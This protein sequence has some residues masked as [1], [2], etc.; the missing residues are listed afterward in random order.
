MFAKRKRHTQMQRRPSMS[1]NNLLMALEF[2]VNC[3]D[4]RNTFEQWKRDPNFIDWLA[5]SY[6]G[7][8][9]NV[10]INIIS[11]F[12]H[13]SQN[14]YAS[15]EHICDT[16]F[17]NNR[18]YYHVYT[19]SW[20]SADYALQQCS[21]TTFDNQEACTLAI[22]EQKKKDYSLFNGTHFK[23]CKL[24]QF[25]AEIFIT[26]FLSIAQDFSKAS[27]VGL[28]EGIKKQLAT[29]HDD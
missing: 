5:H 24:E 15:T 18:V 29:E 11:E 8:M 22:F 27:K 14:K 1:Q 3:A 28:M 10:N 6:T 20:V 17:E 12:H 25:S 19:Y 2:L 7:D 9:T 16:Y 21:F 26:E 13:N 23:L 4:E